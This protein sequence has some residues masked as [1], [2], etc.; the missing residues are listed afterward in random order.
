MAREG[1]YPP[2]PKPPFIPGMEAAGIVAAVGDGVTAPAVGTRVAAFV[3]GG[4]AE[5]VLADAAQA[6]PLPDFV[7][8]PAATSLLVQGLTAYFLLKRAAR[9]RAGQS[10]LVSAAA[11]GVGSLAV[12]MAKLMGAGTVIGLASTPEKRELV[13]SLGADDAIDYTREVWADAV[14]KATGGNG[15]DIYLDATG[16]AAQGGLKPLARLGTWVIYGS[17]SGAQTG[18]SAPD[19]GGM[20]FNWQTIRG[21]TLYEVMSDA[22]AIGSAFHEIFGWLAAGRLHLETKHRFPL[23]QAKQAHEAI[24]ARKTTGKVV[25]EP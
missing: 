2:G 12:Q 13:K 8:F 3:N 7:N 15:I 11:G 5:F 19:L 9:F 21:F 4:Y 10:V 17:Q 18:L 14:K 24:E 20:V 22:P 1:R 25:L 6:V 23:A 16:D